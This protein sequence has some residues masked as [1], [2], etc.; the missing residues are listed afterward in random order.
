MVD[1]GFVSGVCRRRRNS[2][3]RSSKTCAAKITLGAGRDCAIGWPPDVVLARRR[4]DAGK[5]FTQPPKPRFGISPPVPLVIA[6]LPWVAAGLFARRDKNRCRLQK[7]QSQAAT[8]EMHQ[9]GA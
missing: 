1:R 9:S 3:P 2:G 5:K 6:S 8:A 4:T 7:G